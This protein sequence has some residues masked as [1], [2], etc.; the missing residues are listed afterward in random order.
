[1]AEV[2]KIERWKAEK[3]I[4][5]P[6]NHYNLSTHPMNWMELNKIIDQQTFFT[7]APDGIYKSHA[8]GPTVRQ[9][10]SPSMGWV[11]EDKVPSILR[12]IMQKRYFRPFNWPPYQR[13]KLPEEILVECC[14]PAF[15]HSGWGQLIV[16][17]MKEYANQFKIGSPL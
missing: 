9:R 1:M 11:N 3:G 10:L 5:Q 6:Y 14:G 8:F 4:L 16:K 15:V 12:L 2:T 13:I 7:D 17:A